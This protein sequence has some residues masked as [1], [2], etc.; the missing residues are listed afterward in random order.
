MQEILGTTLLLD[1]G[2]RVKP[3]AV[4]WEALTP[5]QVEI[6][7]TAIKAVA[8]DEICQHRDQRIRFEFNE[9]AG[10]VGCADGGS[11]GRDNPDFEYVQSEDGT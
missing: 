4:P 3:V 5:V 7:L 10:G 8:I 11:G 1:D 9:V 2:T 6:A